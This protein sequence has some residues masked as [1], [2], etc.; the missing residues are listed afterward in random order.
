MCFYLLLVFLLFFRFYEVF[1]PELRCLELYNCRA[2][3]TTVHCRICRPNIG[4]LQYKFD[5]DLG[6]SIVFV[7]ITYNVL[8]ETLNPAQSTIVFVTLD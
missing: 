3:S 5:T 2:P 6:S 7:R 1:L 4:Y 8:V